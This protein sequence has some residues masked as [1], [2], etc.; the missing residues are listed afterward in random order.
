METYAGSF[1][2]GNVIGMKIE[3]CGA[4]SE[5]DLAVFESRTARLSYI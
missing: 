1:A 2:D 5:K 3:A 4:I